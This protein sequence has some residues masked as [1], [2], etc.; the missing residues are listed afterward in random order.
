MYEIKIVALQEIQWMSVGQLKVG[1]Y[2][3]FYSE[4][5]NRYSFG[6]GFAVHKS[7]EPYIREFNPVLEKI[8]VLSNNITPLDV[9]LICVNNRLK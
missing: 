6:S 1:E 2:I 7:L 9:M 5:K 4:M 3:I 8:A